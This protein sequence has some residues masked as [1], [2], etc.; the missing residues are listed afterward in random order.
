[1]TAPIVWQET[2]IPIPP[3]D[4]RA[5]SFRAS[6][7]KRRAQHRG[8]AGV[9]VAGQLWER[10]AECGVRAHGEPVALGTRWDEWVQRG[11]RSPI[12]GYPDVSRWFIAIQ[13]ERRRPAMRAR[14]DGAS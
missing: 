2:R 11:T 13:I 8:S 5:L 1:M 3:R 4:L 10:L 12:L 7:T 14:R 9:S 6:L